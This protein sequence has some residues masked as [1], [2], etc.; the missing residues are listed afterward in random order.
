MKELF[1]L[2]KT[3]HTGYESV[4]MGYRLDFGRGGA[5][6]AILLMLLGAGL[7]FSRYPTRT[8]EFGVLRI[9]CCALIFCITLLMASN[10]GKK[11]I[12]LL[13]FTWLL[14]PQM[15]ISWII[16]QTD[17]A[18]SIYYAGLNLVVFASGVVMPLS[19][20][21]NI[22][23]S[24]LTL[25]MYAAACYSNPT[26]IT[27][28]SFQTY[29]I[30]LTFT[31]VA[32]AVCNVFN[33]Q[34][35][36]MLFQLRAELAEKNK[37]QE[38]ANR[39]LAEIKGQMLQQEKMAAIGTLAAG[40]MH[41]INN[42][43]SFCLMAIDL[44]MEDPVAASSSFLM[45][46]LT[47]AKKGMRRVQHIVSD[48]KTFA[49]RNP[50]SKPQVNRFEFSQALATALRFT[51]YELKGVNLT[52]DLEENTFVIGD[53]GA[54]IGVLI[55][56]LNNAVL[57]MNKVGKLHPAIHISAKAHGQRLHI[58][59]R[60]NGPG[61]SA[62]NLTRIF[63]PFFTTRDVGQGLGL[64]LSIS[65]RVIEQHGSILMAESVVG[66]WTKMIF[67]LPRAEPKEQ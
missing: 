14:L 23:L 37:L 11:R 48:L 26:W 19:F 58:I 38:K 62:E 50:D 66:E 12:Q 42:P 59:V 49:Y 27:Q 15:L 35:R 60:D 53:E 63:E 10:W 22:S 4:V 5:Y 17:G 36:F 56:L 32:S 33:E 18:D 28:R 40:L 64:G 6:T 30:L 8:F 29:A 31:G 34:A 54:I 61:I 13:T 41:E 21:Q 45:E 25:V 39:D 67:D 3:A 52:Q 44:S 55:N 1:T 65:Y 47:D 57:A 7:D 51:V 24:V 20:W 46:C 43:V 16:A 2:A 9:I